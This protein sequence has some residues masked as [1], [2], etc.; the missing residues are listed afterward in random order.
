[1]QMRPMPLFESGDSSGS[2]S[3]K[4]LFSA[5]FKAVQTGGVRLENLIRLTVRGGWPGSLGLDANS[6]A[7]LPKAYLKNVIEEDIRRVDGVNRDTR[8]LLLLLRSREDGVMVIP[9]TALKQ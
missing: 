7:E 9:I 2:I 6:S 4:D 5:P 3:L 8:K 1:M